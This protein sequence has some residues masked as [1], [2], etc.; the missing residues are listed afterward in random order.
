[1]IFSFVIDIKSRYIY[2]QRLFFCTFTLKGNISGLSQM[3]QIC[4]TQYPT[5]NLTICP[6]IIN[7]QSNNCQENLS[8][9]EQKIVQ[10]IYFI[11]K[12]Q[13]SIAGYCVCPICEVFVQPNHCQ[14]SENSDRDYRQYD[15]HGN[16][17]TRIPE[18]C[19]PR[20]NIALVTDIHHPFIKTINVW[21]QNNDHDNL[22]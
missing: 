1:M 20:N 9:Y 18:L 6:W 21:N 14:R 5:S 7:T 11:S 10:L 19:L 17:C 2:L 8:P 16:L 13:L 15:L 3:Y 22:K 12:F 4:F